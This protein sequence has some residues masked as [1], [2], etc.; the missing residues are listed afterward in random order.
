MSVISEINGSTASDPRIGVNA[1]AKGRGVKRGRTTYGTNPS[2]L[3]SLQMLS[4]PLTV[5]LR[6]PKP[7]SEPEE[8]KKGTTL[9][10]V[11]RSQ[12]RP[13]ISC[14]QKLLKQGERFELDGKRQ[15]VPTRLLDDRIGFRWN[16]RTVR[17]TE[18]V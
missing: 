13:D 17:E 5:H 3:I 15:A 6:R 1:G 2:D 18:Q 12:E 14:Y 11:S 10:L 7:E 8:R 16:F 4:G 9:T